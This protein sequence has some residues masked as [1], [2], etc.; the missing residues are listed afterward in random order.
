MW[1]FPQSNGSIKN[2]IYSTKNILNFLSVSNI[3]VYFSVNFS[4]LRTHFAIICLWMMSSHC[5]RTCRLYCHYII[6]FRAGQKFSF[7]FVWTPFKVRNVSTKFCIFLH[8]VF[9]NYYVFLVNI[10]EHAVF[11]RMG[12]PKGD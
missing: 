2:T 12:T 8:L 9:L 11:Q 7:F 6:Y 10:M 3:G 1:D 5:H 4:V